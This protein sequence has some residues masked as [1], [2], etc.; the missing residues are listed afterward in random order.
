[1]SVH[2]HDAPSPSAALTSDRGYAMAALLVAMSVMA[3]MMTVALPVWNTAAKRE[4]EAELVFRGEQYARAI[5]LYQRK[6]ANALPPSVDVLLND[7][8]LRKKYKDPITGGDFQ[9]LSGASVQANAGVP[10]GQVP[11]AGLGRGTAGTST[12]PGQQT[13]SSRGVGTGSS[14]TGSFGTGSSATGSLGTG[15]GTTGTT[16]GSGFGLGTGVGAGPGGS[17]P[18][19]IMGVTSTST[20]K[21]LRL[22]NGRGAYNEWTFVAVQ[23]SLN[24]GAGGQGAATPGGPGGRAG[25]GGRGSQT[26]GPQRGTGPNRPGGSGF[27]TPPGG[28]GTPQQPGPGGFGR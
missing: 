12:M 8:Y 19:G 11:G 27:S 16:A 25:Q 15:R 13:G 26:P 9:L 4:K 21:S 2:A 20:D 28:F 17:V 1:M 22:Y 7:R 6:F 24:A 18:G 14:G 5:A 10:G 23:R 3:I